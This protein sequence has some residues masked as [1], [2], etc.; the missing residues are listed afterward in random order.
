MEF[1][2]PKKLL[3]VGGISLASVVAFGFV[4]GNYLSTL[5]L[6][7]ETV[8]RAFP[9]LIVLFLSVSL[10]IV[11]SLLADRRRLVFYLLV[12][13][14]LFVLPFG[15]LPLLWRMVVA[16]VLLLGFAAFCFQAKDIH[17]A[18]T[19]FSAYYYV[20]LMR[21]FFLLFGFILGIVLFFSIN[22]ALGRQRVEIPEK[23]LR[24][25]VSQIV[26]AVGGMLKQQFGGRVPEDQL[27]PLVEEQ[28]VTI[29]KQVGL[30]IELEG[31]SRS[32][33][34]V[35]E[36]IIESINTKLDETVSPFKG[37]AP[38]LVAG[39]LVLTLFV[40]TP[41]AGLFGGL[42]FFFV[43]RFLILVRVLRFEEVERTV[44][45]LALA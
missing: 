17:E 25:A 16:V 20:G 40:L 26:G 35:T 5:T 10:M 3:L 11:F 21:H 1:E 34:Q 45:R 31:Q 32:F 9:I 27:A 30:K 12:A 37:Y 19:G 13:V 4:L 33:T 41:F 28:L 24:P 44:K 2:L 38:F 6:S 7:V 22:Q 14:A 36:R 29:L 23:I 42:I 43:Y 15:S 8:L 39:S 18:Y